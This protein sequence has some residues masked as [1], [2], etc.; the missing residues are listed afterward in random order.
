MCKTKWKTD[1]NDI[2]MYIDTNDCM[3]TI[4]IHIER[5]TCDHELQRS[6]Q[7]IG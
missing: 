4:T 2:F 7:L 5:I 6:A 1:C 3:Y